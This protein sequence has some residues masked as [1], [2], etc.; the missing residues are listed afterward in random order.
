MKFSIALSSLLLATGMSTIVG[1][2]NTLELF[3]GIVVNFFYGRLPSSV[4]CNR[5]IKYSMLSDE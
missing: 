4:A 2:M 3:D 5:T 1:I